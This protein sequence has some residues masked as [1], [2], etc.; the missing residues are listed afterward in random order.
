M[1]L[2]NTCPGIFAT[3]RL[4][5]CRG[6]EAIR[7]DTPTR[8]RRV[9]CMLWKTSIKIINLYLKL[10]CNNHFLPLPTHLLT[11]NFHSLP[12]QPLDSPHRQLPPALPLI[13]IIPIVLAPHTSS[14]TLSSP[15]PPTSYSLHPSQSTLTL[16]SPAPPVPSTSLQARDQAELGC[17]PEY[18]ATGA[19]DSISS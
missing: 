12:H 15:P 19:G 11:R 9:I 4:R 17:Q 2:P 16:L 6:L 5:H 1:Q 13:P 8:R 3:A 18:P 10:Q 7:A 14:Q